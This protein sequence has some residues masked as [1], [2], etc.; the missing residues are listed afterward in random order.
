[1]Q[2]AP[3]SDMVFIDSS[4]WIALLRNLGPALVQALRKLLA[5]GQAV[6]SPVIYEEVLQGA[7][8]RENFVRLREYFPTQTFL[9]P[10]H[11][12]GTPA[13][14]AERYTRCRWVGIALRNAYDCLIAQTAIENS[15]EL[16][17]DDRGF[18]AIARV[19]PSLLLH[20]CP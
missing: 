6:L 8:N 5:A 3:T 19:Q 17:A 12:I 9:L 7:T 20:S 16:L 4:V 10:K 14:A 11:P 15:I 18:T 13:A 2:F 1:M